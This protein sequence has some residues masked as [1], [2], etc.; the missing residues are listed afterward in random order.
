[1]QYTSDFR[2]NGQLA[3]DSIYWAVNKY[4]DQKSWFCLVHH[5]N[6][7]SDSHTYYSVMCFTFRGLIFGFLRLNTSGSC[8]R[9]HKVGC[10]QGYRKNDKSFINNFLFTKIYDLICFM[11]I[12]W[13]NNFDVL[14]YCWLVDIYNKYYIWSNKRSGHNNKNDSND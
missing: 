5:V 13:F 7:F 3:I 14:F 8:Y 10:R 1:M 4:K 2:P 11:G 6:I 12:L 9:C